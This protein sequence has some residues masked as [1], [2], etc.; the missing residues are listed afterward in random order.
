MKEQ[1]GVKDTSS[2]LDLSKQQDISH[3]EQAENNS[4]ESNFVVIIHETVRKIEL[5]DT[6]GTEHGVSKWRCDEVAAS[7][8]TQQGVRVSRIIFQFDRKAISLYP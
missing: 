6:L 1:E 2:S 3:Q 8:E 5:S 4:S 7:Y